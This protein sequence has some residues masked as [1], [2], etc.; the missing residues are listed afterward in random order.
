MLQLELNV[1]CAA[2]HIN[3]LVIIKCANNVYRIKQALF[4]MFRVLSQIKCSTN[5][6]NDDYFNMFLFSICVVV[7][8]PEQ[9]P[10]YSV[11]RI[12]NAIINCSKMLRTVPF[13]T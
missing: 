3:F 11:R 7:H 13:I 5:D 6:D 10:D 9:A 2:I 12:T 4:C 1:L 8:V